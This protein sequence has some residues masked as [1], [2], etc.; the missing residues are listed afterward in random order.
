MYHVCADNIGT[1]VSNK[2]SGAKVVC[3][4]GNFF[5]HLYFW[6]VKVPL[7]TKKGS[8]RFLF[9]ILDKIG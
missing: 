9:L 6:I 5:D 7:G 3:Q 8:K 2:C 1:G 4:C